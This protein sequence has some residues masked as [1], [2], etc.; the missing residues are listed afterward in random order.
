MQTVIVEV[1]R[2]TS[3]DDNGDPRFEV[4]PEVRMVE[5]SPDVL[6]A[7]DSASCYRVDVLSG[8]ARQWIEEHAE[9][10]PCLGSLMA[11]PASAIE[12]LIESMVEAGLKVSY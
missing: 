11:V 12:H 6:V 1:A 5:Q 7:R 8:E 9:D 10:P 2:A 3:F 4:R